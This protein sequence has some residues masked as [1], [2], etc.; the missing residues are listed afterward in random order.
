MAPLGRLPSPLDDH[1]PPQREAARR[2]RPVGWRRAE[3]R[4]LLGALG[5]V[6]LLLLG[7]GARGQVPA[8]TATQAHSGERPPG[9]E[10]APRA[11]AYAALSPAAC[12]EELSRRAIAFERVAPSPRGVTHAVS[13]TGPLRGVVV[14]PAWARSAG[15][16]GAKNG[17]APDVI[18]CRLVLALDDFSGLLA[19]RGVR[20]LRHLSIY[21]KGARVAGTRR[22]SQHGA[23]LAIDVGL[24][25]LQDG[26]RLK[27]EDEWRGTRGAPVCDLA[28]EPSG[29][30]DASRL[31]RELVCE[32]ARRGL[33]SVILTPNYD[34]AHRDH[35][36]LDIGTRNG[37][38]LTL[39]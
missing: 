18:D 37:G 17:A 25:V 29:E 11:A 8:A 3:R 16:S 12:E 24:L 27:I 36:H 2:A 19:A 5:V 9:L 23:A 4:G 38:S 28:R 31:L 1:A 22:P 15:R 21:R 14:L 30:T 35:L 20:E 7:C 34:H 33:F 10:G 6:A 32:A 39:R 26:T 13:L